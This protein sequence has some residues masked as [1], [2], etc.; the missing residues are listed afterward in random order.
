M[1][2]CPGTDALATIA[3]A[4]EWDVEQGLKHLS[5]CEACSEELRALRDV[6]V[7]YDEREAVPESVVSR[8]GSAIDAV[9]ARERARGQR[10]HNLGDLVEAALAGLT[11]VTLLSTGGVDVPL[12]MR[13][14][15]FALVATSLFAYRT[16][17]SSHSTA[18]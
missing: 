11:A 6:R 13:A 14:G 9:A 4:L 7:A 2:N 12:L 10:V 8:I 17:R 5:S 18:V 3:G 15:V 1:T 16:I